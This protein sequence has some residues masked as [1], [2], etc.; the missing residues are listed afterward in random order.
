MLG[1]YPLAIELAAGRCRALTAAELSVRLKS[2]P[3]LLRARGKVGRGAT[4]DRHASITAAL[5]W[6]LEQLDPATR[7]LLERAA[8]FSSDFDLTAAEAILPVDG[9]A[10]NDVVEHLEEL[11]EHHLVRR[12]HRRGRY[13]ILEPIRQI[14]S[15]AATSGEGLVRRHGTYFV[16]LMTDVGDGLHGPDEAAWSARLEDELPNVRDAVDWAIS[17]QEW[18]RLELMMKRMPLVVDYHGF[19]HPADWAERMLEDPAA[20]ATRFQATALTN[21]AGMLL[22]ER[23]EE[24]ENLLGKLE[25]RGIDASMK[26]TF[27]HLRRQQQWGRGDAAAGFEWSDRC[28]EAAR[29]DGDLVMIALGSMG[30]AEADATGNPSI[31]SVARGYTYSFM[32]ADG[33]STA[34]RLMEASYEAALESNNPLALF[35]RQL[36]LG[37]ALIRAGDVRRGALFMAAGIERGVRLS[38]PD[39]R[40]DHDR[41]SGQLARNRRRGI[42]RAH[43]LGGG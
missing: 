11:V 14:V 26:S 18:S 12:D 23:F 31:R 38:L 33:R 4:S 2:R 10:P 15:S 30:V 25:E 36:L 6:S 8:L 20:D 28:V 13:R 32:D 29:A 24:C 27:C 9:V 3:D 1:N 42:C 43:A 41:V 37:A 16:S 5:D 17:N 19:L 40:V 7:A 39:A 35:G 22:M 34:R 21:A